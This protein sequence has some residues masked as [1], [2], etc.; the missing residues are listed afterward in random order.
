V[1]AE[2]ISHYRI[3][4]KLGG[5]GMGVVYKAEDTRLHRFVALKFLPP[6]LAKDAQSL[7]RFQR[8]AQAASALNHPNICTIYDIGEE[9]G[10]AF[11]AMEYLEG[12]TL[13]H[14]I[15]GQPLET[16]RL[17]TLAIEM[18]DALDAA[19][20][21]GII[22]RDIKPANIFITKRGHAKILD[23]GLAKVSDRSTVAAGATLDATLDDPNLTSPGTALGTVAYM[24][25]EQALGKPLD[26][27][28]DLFSLG[29]TLYEMATGKQAFSGSTSAAIFDAILHSNPPSADRVNPVLPAGLNQIIAKLI[30]KDP[31]LRYQTAA[32]LR[33]DLKRLHRDTTSGHS[34]IAT[35]AAERRKRKIPAWAL[36]TSVAAVFVI[37][38]IAAWVYSHA[39]ATY[40]GPP[41]RVVPL[42]SS[43]GVK[44]AVALSPDGNEVAFAWQEEQYRKLNLAN[45]YVQLVG[46][47]AP[48][49]LT[50]AKP[51]DFWFAGPAWS[52]DGRFI[53]VGRIDASGAAYYAIPALGGSER[54]IG[55]AN[56]LEFVN[57]VD[58]SP[59]GKFLV[60]A[61]AAA[62]GSSVP[63]IFLISVD[64]GEKR[65]L[66]IRVPEGH[67]MADPVFSSDGKNIAFS[68]GSGY[69]SA[70]VCIAPVS[71]GT[72]TVLTSQQSQISEMAWTADSRRIVFATRDTLSGLSEVSIEGG[73]VKPVSFNSE[74]ATGVSISRQGNRLAFLTYKADT[75]IWRTSVPAN[76]HELPNRIVA[77]TR[78]DSAPEISP[79]GKRL[80]FASD[81]SGSYE[82]YL[83]GV[84][85]SNPVQLTSVKASSDTGTPRWSPD[86]KLIAFDSRLEGHADIFV[87]SAEGGAP[88][89]LTSEP[90]DN[91]IP[92]W[93]RDGHWIYFISDRGGAQQVWKVPAEGGVAVQVT[94]NVANV[95]LEA[96]DGKS[97]Y[98]FRDGAIWNSS[99]A[100]ENET[101]LVDCPGFMGWRL[102]HNAIWILNYDITPT[103]LIAFDLATRKKTQVG[104]LDIGPL[105]F[106]ATGFDVTADGKSIVYTRVDSLD[107]DIMLVENF[108]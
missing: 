61:E 27:R 106:V 76:G 18:A 56:P 107:S 80:A 31:D 73:A 25:P 22:H 53:A 40:S 66:N 32:D 95:A 36:I 65:A 37:L 33:A 99:L 79:D 98:Y 67:Y 68:C 70:E 77:S 19:H 69:L 92:A 48:L 34:A 2:N 43:P 55:S 35:V 104:T 44:N 54:R 16:E 52:F 96:E 93:S 81:R 38:A 26:A 30:E 85:G 3:V 15:T 88:R 94:K 41:M 4:E 75:N 23:F 89:R 21:Q 39:P 100:G 1:D 47:G 91:Q 82:I 72:A 101:R 63:G 10:R 50:H 62:P 58:W 90:Y 87:V 86:G 5:G 105:A 24:S 17:L 20:S 13:K 71:G 42:T 28:S 74:N 14:M 46:A 108:H 102:R 57:G 78:E 83:S 45:F 49:Q 29:L 9:Q 51:G 59:D 64:S 84:D 7:A 97:I 12:I 11:I 8:E 6:D 103:P 60:V